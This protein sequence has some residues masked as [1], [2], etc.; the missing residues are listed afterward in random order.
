VVNLYKST[1]VLNFKKILMNCA[2]IFS[3]LHDNIKVFRALV[4][5]VDSVQAK[6]KPV[7]NKWSVLEVI[8]HLYDEERE[9]Y[10]LRLDLILHHPEKDWPP[11]D[12]VSWA[13]ERKYNQRDL[14]E[15][16]ELF[17]SEREKSVVWLNKLSQS[18]W[19]K[20]YNHPKIGKLHAGDML[21]SWLAHDFMHIRQ[22]ANIY[23]DYH[24]NQVQPFSTKYAAP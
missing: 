20:F 8:N 17:I 5:G 14:Q 16:L 3:K 21:S 6:W 23:L 11:V 19:N 12:P 10:R 2:N 22:I 15:S 4:K 18:D 7:E 24:N 13:V 1:K 9:D